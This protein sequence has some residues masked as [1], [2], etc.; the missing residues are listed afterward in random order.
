[1]NNGTGRRLTCAWLRYTGSETAAAFTK[2]GTVAFSGRIMAFRGVV[3]TG[4]PYGA[5]STRA[6]AAS[7]TVT[8]NA[9]TTTNANA[10]VVF[11][12]NLAVDAT[13]TTQFS[14]WT[15]VGTG[16]MTEAVDNATNTGSGSCVGAAYGIQATAGT[17]GTTTATAA[18]SALNSAFLLELVPASTNQTVSPTAISSGEAFGTPTV[19]S[20][21]TVNTRFYLPSSGAPPI[22]PTDWGTVW[23]HVGARLET[24]LS[25]TK[26]GTAKAFK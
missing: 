26:A 21:P 11:L 16:A 4:N 19:T 3:A 25:T 14:G 24:T 12:A 9:I 13:S 2:T 22:D 23:T 7:A 18:S 6:N 17:T 5:T 8:A 10:M 15:S 20:P 1:L